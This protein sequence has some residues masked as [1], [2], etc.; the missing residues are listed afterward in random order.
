MDFFFT[1]PLCS[2]QHEKPYFLFLNFLRRLSFLKNLIR[3]RIWF[4]CIIRKDAIFSR[5]YDLIFR[6]I[7][8]DDLSR[9]IHENMICSVYLG[10]M[11]FLFLTNLMLSLCQK[12]KM[13]FSRKNNISGIIKKVGNHPR[14][15]GFSTVRRI[16]DDKKVYFYN[17]V[18]IILCTLLEIF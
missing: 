6:R 14:K 12:A 16:K 8:K 17:K 5:K 15:Y 18:P 4:S 2:T 3:I 7:T 10:K 9:K 11:M 13:I 1:F